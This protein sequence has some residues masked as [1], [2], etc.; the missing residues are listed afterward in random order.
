LNWWNKNFVILEKTMSAAL[1]HA[2]QPEA[3]DFVTLPEYLAQEEKSE[4]KHEY[5][6]GQVRAMAGGSPR[7]A[8]I[9]F[10]LAVA[11]GKHLQG[12]PCRGANGDQRIR[13]EEA[14]RSLYPDLV[15]S[16]PPERYSADDPHAL[17]NP[18]LIIEVLSPSTQE[19]DR[20][21]KFDCY[22]Q[23][24]ELQH[25]VLVSQERVLVE[26]FQRAQ[27]GWL[28]R[29]FNRREDI[30]TIS[31]LEIEIPLAEIYDGVDVP[32]GLLM[33]GAPLEEQAT[34]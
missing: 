7:H 1:A 10:N 2:Y 22:A 8:K 30:V 21:E 33:M 15:V 34:D 24:P 18:I 31:D 3:V 16:C 25:Y 12:K 23:I 9:G 20:N 14:D 19:F 29:R 28:L 11:V 6:A 17:V 26:H 32:S 27:D 5:H 13:I 4:I